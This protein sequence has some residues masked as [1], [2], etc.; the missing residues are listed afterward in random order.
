MPEWTI[1][2]NNV[3]HHEYLQNAINNQSDYRDCFKAILRQ[4]CFIHNCNT[5]KYLY[6]LNQSKIFS[7]Y[8]NDSDLNEEKKAI[9][10]AINKQQ[11]HIDNLIT[12]FHLIGVC[13]APRTLEAKNLLFKDYSSD[14]G[15]IFQRLVLEAYMGDCYREIE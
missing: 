1:W 5:A 15:K 4:T 2:N 9:N 13:E 11:Q 14:A 8:G 7:K 6:D 10:D 3:S 12:A